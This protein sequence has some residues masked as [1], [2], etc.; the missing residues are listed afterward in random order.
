M[1]HEMQNGAYVEHVM[2]PKIISRY[3]NQAR[4][5]GKDPVAGARGEKIQW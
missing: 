3:G 5:V 4:L 1:K 2:V